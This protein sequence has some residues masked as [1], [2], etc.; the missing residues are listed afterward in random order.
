MEGDPKT[1]VRPWWVR[2]G[3]WGISSRRSAWTCVWLSIALGVVCVAYG[4]W[5]RL[6]SIGGV[7]FLAALWYVLAIQWVDR[8]ESWS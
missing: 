3:L 6:F 7:W 2:V 8:H 1:V 5:N 4:F